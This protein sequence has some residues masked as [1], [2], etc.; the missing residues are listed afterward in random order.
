MS[1]QI[2]DEETGQVRGMEPLVMTQNKRHALKV[3]SEL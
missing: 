1:Q 2:S 3:K